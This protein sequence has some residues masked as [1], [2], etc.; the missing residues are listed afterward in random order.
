ML[1]PLRR[2][3]SD[4]RDLPMVWDIEKDGRRSYLVG[5]AHFFPYR[6]RAALRRYVRGARSVLVE[7]PLDADA[8]RKVIAAGSARRGASLCD[9]L[10]ARTVHKINRALR[11]SASTLSLHRLCWEAVQGDPNDWL[12]A[13]TRG[14]TPW[15]AFMQLWNRYRAPQGWT[16]STDL[17]LAGIAADLG[18]EVH[19]L[20]TIEE[21]IE[22]LNGIPLGRIVAFLADVDWDEYVRA[23]VKHYLAG[24]LEALVATARVFPTFCESIVD[25]RDPILHSR[26]SPFL[27]A[28][29]A[30]ACVGVVHCPGL[31]RLL[32]G[33]RYRVVP[34][35]A[36]VRPPDA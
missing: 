35:G 22:A 31:I 27:E 17:D 21:Q 25:R 16:Y 28:G 4:E 11:L 8:G 19:P 24:D 1:R 14:L 30:L 36:S 7:G 15:M 23:Y 26:M 9:A 3:L 32:Q 34:A 6:F 20:E 2:L 33:G 12:A 13:R 29:D 5:A 10:D 18:K